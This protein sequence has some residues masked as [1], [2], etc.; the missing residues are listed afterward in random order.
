MP[1]KFEFFF[2]FSSPY[3]YLASTQVEAVA[4]RA[5]ATLIWR[6][7]LLGGVFKTTGNI[8][9][10]H[11]AYKARYLLKDLQNWCEHY[12]LPPLKF[13]EEFPIN[14]LKA[15]RLAI[16][17][18]RA[19]HLAPFVHAV[20]RRVFEEGRDISDVEIL[21]GTLRGLALDP[22]PLLAQV[23]LPEI[24][25]ALRRNTDEAVGRGSFGAPTFFV[26]DEDMYIGND[27][28]MFVEKALTTTGGSPWQR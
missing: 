26:N 27:R 25:D 17:V 11:N 21:R 14:S 19:G 4:K 23:E 8:P 10:V 7:F 22:E 24:K 28:L 13:P 15:I 6:P 5:G 16:A 9:P 18:D 1:G 3:S 2:D 12:G 20:Y